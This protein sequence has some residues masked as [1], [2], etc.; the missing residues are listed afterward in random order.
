MKYQKGRDVSFTGSRPSAVEK[1]IAA[2]NAQDTEGF[3]GAFTPDAVIDDWGHQVVGHDEIRAWNE[4]EF[5]GPDVRIEHSRTTIATQR[6]L[7]PTGG[8][9]GIHPGCSGA[10][11]SQHG[12]L[13]VCQRF[14]EL[15]SILFHFPCPAWHVKCKAHPTRSKLRHGGRC[16]RNDRPSHPDPSGGG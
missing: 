16:S 6:W 7:H 12:I 4:Y 14:P 11:P 15:A 9:E 8:P 13:Q 10:K 3:V 1:L 5:T 2:V